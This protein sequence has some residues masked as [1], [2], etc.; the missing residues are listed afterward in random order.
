MMVTPTISELYQRMAWNL[1]GNLDRTNQCH[2]YIL[3]IM[4]L[5]TRYLYAIPLKRIDAESVAVGLMEVISHTGIPVDLLLYQG[6]VFLGK[7][8]K[9]L[10]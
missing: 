4:C 7:V 6:P 3:T 10:C 1:V 8:I 9:E 2:R 5:G